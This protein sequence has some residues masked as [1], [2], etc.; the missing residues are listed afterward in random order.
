MNGNPRERQTGGGYSARGAP[1]ANGA[2]LILEGRGISKYFPIKSGAFGRARG[3]VRAIERLDFEIREGETLGV[4]GESGC[5]KTTLA[6][7]IVG[8][9]GAEGSLRYADRNGGSFDVLSRGVGRDRMLSYRRDVQIIFQ[10]PFSS[11]DPRMRV[12]EIL[13]EP[14]DVHGM[15]RDRHRAGAIAADL[16]ERVG[17]SADYMNRYPHEFSGGQRQRIAIARALPLSPRLIVCDEPT[18]ALDVSVQSQ[19]VNL[20]RDI[21]ARDHLAYLFIS[22]NLDLVHHMSDRMIVM[23]LGSVME[24]GDSTSVFGNPL[25]PYTQALMASIPSWDP[26]DKRMFSVNLPGEPPSPIDVPPGCPFH[27][28]CPRAAPECG[29]WKPELRTIADGHR[30][31]CHFA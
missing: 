14:L 22:H 27:P 31:A 13:R 15:G 17:L 1:G 5:G 10:D 4:V 25:H 26:S 24:E 6:N 16:L 8:L 19:V 21:Q 2:P 23:Y 12:G 18:S 30:A 20:L 9:C 3:R 29:E 7:V 28:R 11:L